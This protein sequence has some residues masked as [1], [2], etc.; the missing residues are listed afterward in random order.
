M[1]KDLV[2]LALQVR[3]RVEKDEK[4]A[5]EFSNKMKDLLNFDAK[6]NEA[7]NN[8]LLFTALEPGYKDD[9]DGIIKNDCIVE[10]DY[11]SEAKTFKQSV[12]NKSFVRRINTC[13]R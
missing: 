10:N 11:C 2:E 6:N 12:A 7:L 3:Y 8:Y 5:S 4:K 9:V 13:E 1:D